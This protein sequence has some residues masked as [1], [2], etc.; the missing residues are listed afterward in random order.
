[1]LQIFVVSAFNSVKSSNRVVLLFPFQVVWRRIS[2]PTKETMDNDL[3]YGLFLVSLL[4][5]LVN[6]VAL[7]LLCW[8]LKKTR[9]GLF[10]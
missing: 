10:D 5:L 7:L 4:V 9:H 6:L 2:L 8:T 1:M 3:P